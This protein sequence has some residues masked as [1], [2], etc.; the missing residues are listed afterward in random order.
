MLGIT[1]RKNI[2][3]DEGNE[4]FN[5]FL[6]FIYRSKTYHLYSLFS[7]LFNFNQAWITA[8]SF[9]HDRIL[10]LWCSFLLLLPFLFIFWQTQ[11]IKIV[12]SNPD[13]HCNQSFLDIKS[14]S[15]VCLL[16]FWVFHAFTSGIYMM[17]FGMLQ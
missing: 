11:E 17:V 14:I 16:V 8:N 4:L 12:A 13:A 5:S 1:H 6:I 15:S 10:T 7:F 3:C 2:W 9:I